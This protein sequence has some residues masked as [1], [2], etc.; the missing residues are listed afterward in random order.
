MGFLGVLLYLAIV[1]DA[2]E[3]MLL[4]RRIR[5]QLRPVR[6]FFKWSWSV[7]KAI[8]QRMKRGRRR[9]AFLSLYGPL[10]MVLLLSFWALGLI[11]SFALMQSSLDDKGLLSLSKVL[12]LSGA[13]FF[14]VGYGDVQSLSQLGK[15]LAVFEAGSGLAFIAA[16][17]SY[18]PVL[19]Q[20]F[21]RRE[22]LVIRLD[23]RAASPP[24]AVALLCRH[25]ELEAMP[26]LSIFLTEWEHWCA[27]IVES[28][29]SYPMLSYYRSQHD[30]QSWLAALAT[31]L[32]ACALMLTGFSGVRTFQARMTFAMGR[33]AALELCQVFHL[34][35]ARPINDRLPHERFEILNSELADSGLNFSDLDEAESKLAELRAT[36]EPFLA[37][38]ARHFLLQL[39]RWRIA[40]ESANWEVSAGGQTAKKMVEAAPAMPE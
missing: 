19:Y 11:V 37:T 30:N 33:L 27:E 4:P 16:T 36:Y 6:F 24:T 23:A 32:D 14:T 40:E 17:I 22:A 5:R 20:L 25:S 8:A 18:L 31:V 2:F 28:H 10:S 29:L 26:D 12:Y 3:V 39:P 1:S 15:G 38:L 7:W 35:P 13:A 34:K 21:S 9:D